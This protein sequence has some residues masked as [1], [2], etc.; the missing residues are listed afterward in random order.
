MIGS[1]TSLCW[2]S[3]NTNMISQDYAQRAQDNKITNAANYKKWVETHTVAEIAT[4]NNARSQLIR[5]FEFKTTSPKIHDERMPKRPTSAFGQYYRAKNSDLGLP[6]TE[7]MKALSAQWKSLSETE[8]KPYVDLATAE[9]TKY[10][11]EMEK[12]NA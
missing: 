12:V 1:L 7:N 9:A 10:H 3:F 2:N 5:K 4:A 11:K 6:A 8:K